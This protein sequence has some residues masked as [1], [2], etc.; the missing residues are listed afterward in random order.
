[1]PRRAGANRGTN[2][3]DEEAERRR[4]I[5]L[6]EDEREELKEI[7]REDEEDASPAERKKR[8][9]KEKRI[10]ERFLAQTLEEKEEWYATSKKRDAKR[11]A[12]LAPHQAEETKVRCESARE[13]YERVS[14]KERPEVEKKF[15][16]QTMLLNLF[17]KQ[18]AEKEK[19]AGSDSS[20]DSSADEDDD[21]NADGAVGDKPT[22]LDGEED[23]PEEE[24]NVVDGDLG[25]DDDDDE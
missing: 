2:S 19:E 25:E 10:D 9:R 14:K 23:R 20:A 3:D 16:Y 5:A 6:A 24:A 21:D 13:E 4:H 7:E 18:Q 8:A 22:I 11:G 15:P 12:Q 17:R 1:M